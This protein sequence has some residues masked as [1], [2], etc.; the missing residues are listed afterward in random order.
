MDFEISMKQIS[1]RQLNP[2]ALV[3]LCETGRCE[4][5]LPEILFDMDYPGH[6]MRRIKSVAVTVTCM[7]GPYTGLSCTLRLLEHKY[8]INSVVKDKNDYP[9]R[10]DDVHPDDRFMTTDVPITTIAVSNGQNDLGLFKL[11]FRDDR[12]LPFEGAGVISKWRLELASNFRQF[13]YDTLSDVILTLRYT[14]RDGGDKLRLAAEQSL[15]A[16]VTCK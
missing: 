11:N 12:Y 4:F 1:L 13:D 6:Y 15:L 8:R 2:L 9:E 14:A 5:S 7:G 10:I 3:E 16:Y